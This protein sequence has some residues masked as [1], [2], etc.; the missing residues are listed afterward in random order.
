MKT[1][2]I[3]TIGRKLKVKIGSINQKNQISQVTEQK[4]ANYCIDPA[5]RTVEVRYT[6]SKLER[7]FEGI[8]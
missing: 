4:A 1:F 5:S 7:E 8:F 3:Q 6:A 2:N